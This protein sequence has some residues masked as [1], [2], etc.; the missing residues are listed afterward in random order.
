MLINVTVSFR[1]FAQSNLLES[2]AR[3][4]R[5]EN[6]G[7]SSGDYVVWTLGALAVTVALWWIARRQA[8]GVRKPID[9][10]R[11]LF[12][13]LCEAHDLPRSEV[14]FLRELARR[15]EAPDP[16][17]MFVEPQRFTAATVGLDAETCRR[18]EHLRNWIFT[19][20]TP[21]AGV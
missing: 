14:V 1:L 10:P 3:E 7:V 2:M 9:D 4:F 17:Q 19:G 11:K 18:A 8:D 5:G 20:E 12:R 21:T 6:A 15:S 16:S 13:E